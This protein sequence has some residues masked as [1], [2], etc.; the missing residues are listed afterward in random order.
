MSGWT[1]RAL[2]PE[3]CVGNSGWIWSR[4]APR[5]PENG[6][7]ERRQSRGRGR[8]GAYRETSMSKRVE[9]G[10]PA[11]PP[12]PLP[13]PLLPAAAAYRESSIATRMAPARHLSPPGLSNDRD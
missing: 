8:M 3:V 13:A 1:V 12:A 4:E 6:L 10:T 11:A 5:E 7:G 9:P 2:I